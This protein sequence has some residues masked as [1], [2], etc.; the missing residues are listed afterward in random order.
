[1]I[2]RRHEL[3]APIY[4]AF[5]AG[6]EFE[7]AH[8][9]MRDARNLRAHGC[10]RETA[11]TFVRLARAHHRSYLSWLAGRVAVQP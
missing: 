5:Q 4:L 11:C 9:R 1:M 7:M 2:R 3:S 8:A 6:R 10:S